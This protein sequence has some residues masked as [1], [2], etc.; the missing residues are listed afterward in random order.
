MHMQPNRDKLSCL[1]MVCSPQL[2]SATSHRL[3]VPPRGTHAC[4]LAYQS[5][6][7]RTMRAK[8][9]S[10]PVTCETT[11]KREVIEEFCAPCHGLF[12]AMRCEIN[13]YEIIVVPTSN[14]FSRRRNRYEP[15]H[16]IAFPRA[17]PGL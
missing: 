9:G 10:V 15:A 7:A 11:R 16:S 2:P 6:G 4:P 14:L 8:S 5:R 1:A 12:R 17:T 13:R 3:C